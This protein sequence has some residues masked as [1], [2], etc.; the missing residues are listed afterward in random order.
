MILALQNSSLKLR[1]SEEVASSI[2]RRKEVGQIFPACQLRQKLFTLQS[3][4]AGKFSLSP[5]PH[6][7]YNHSGWQHCNWKQLPQ[8]LQLNKVIANQQFCTTNAPHVV[9]LILNRLDNIS[10]G[11]ALLGSSIRTSVDKGLLCHYFFEL[12]LY[13]LFVCFSISEWSECACIGHVV[14]IW[15]KYCDTGNGPSENLK[16]LVCCGLV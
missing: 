12:F 5:E 7:H 6:C 11:L 4:T 13:C 10:H 2:E 14:R 16:K 8:L 15:S 1:C 3:A 9:E